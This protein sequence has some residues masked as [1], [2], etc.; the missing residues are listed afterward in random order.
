M[1][2]MYELERNKVDKKVRGTETWL[3]EMIERRVLP[4]LKLK[5]GPK[6]SPK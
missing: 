6:I 3:R 5:K 2:F 4:R 1:N